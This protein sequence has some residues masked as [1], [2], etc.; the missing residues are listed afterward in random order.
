MK[1]TEPSLEVASTV[2]AEKLD[3]LSTIRHAVTDR[4]RAGNEHC[5]FVTVNLTYNL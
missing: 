2:L 5:S 3:K 1:T 4:T